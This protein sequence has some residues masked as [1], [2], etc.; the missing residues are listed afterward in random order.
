MR[1]KVGTMTEEL[2]H[3]VARIGVRL[4]DEAYM[5]WCAAES[6]CEEALR[7]WS[8]GT[9]RGG[10]E[11][12]SRYRAALDREE[13]AARDLQKLY[14]VAQSYPPSLA[15]PENRTALRADGRPARFQ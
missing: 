11:A 3:E 10:A 14:E 9:K 8:A 5:A 6:E 13:A 1:G 12:Y 15:P 2:A 4:L 7:G